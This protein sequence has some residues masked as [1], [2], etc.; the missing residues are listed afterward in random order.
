MSVMTDVSEWEVL[1]L[2]ILTV[3]SFVSLRG[4]CTWGMIADSWDLLLIMRLQFI[5]V[6][7]IIT[8]Q[9]YIACF[10]SSFCFTVTNHIFSSISCSF[11]IMSLIARFLD[12]DS[13]REY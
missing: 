9:H 4:F 10:T 2:K 12:S 11:I 13:S 3:L 5:W 1:V 6:S 7:M 8:L